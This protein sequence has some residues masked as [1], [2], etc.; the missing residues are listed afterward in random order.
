MPL[1][2]APQPLIQPSMDSQTNPLQQQVPLTRHADHSTNTG[3]EPLSEPANPRLGRWK[4][5]VE[6]WV[7]EQ[8]TSPDRPIQREPR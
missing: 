5:T 3:G 2:P 1:P 4:D 8:A 6:P 7:I